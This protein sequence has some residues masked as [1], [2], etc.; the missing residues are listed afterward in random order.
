[1]RRAGFGLGLAVT[2]ACLFGCGAEPTDA[3]VLDAAHWVQ[4]AEAQ[5][6]GGIAP[7]EGFYKTAEKKAPGITDAMTRLRQVKNKIDRGDTV[8]AKDDFKKLIASFPTIRLVYKND[9]GRYTRLFEQ[10]K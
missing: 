2:L 5:A 3:D 8:D 4:M 10:W 9:E 1:M 6:K 7:D